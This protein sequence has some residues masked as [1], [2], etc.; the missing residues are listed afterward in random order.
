MKRVVTALGVLLAVT[1]FAGDRALTAKEAFA[2]LKSL[3]GT[4][5][6]STKDGSYQVIYKLTGAGSALIETQMA[7]TST[8]M[9]SIYH[10]DGPN[11]IMTHYCAA[12]NQPTMKYKSGD[13]KSIDFDFLKGS[14]MKPKDMHIH[15]ARIRIL[16]PDSLESDWIGFFKGK[17]AGTTTFKLKRIGK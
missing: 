14:N 8:E 11:L 7:G 12:G 1:A 6:E 2:K 13:E 9:V 15:A 3:V 4:W 16:S 10:M 17:N 5:Q